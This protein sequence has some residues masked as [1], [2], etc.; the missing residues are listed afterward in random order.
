MSE[1]HESLESSAEASSGVEALL[2]IGVFEVLMAVAANIPGESDLEV[3]HLAGCS[4]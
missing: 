4:D 1:R 2:K 3:Y